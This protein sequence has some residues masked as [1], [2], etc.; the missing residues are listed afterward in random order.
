MTEAST[1]GQQRFIRGK[2][3]KGRTCA[4]LDVEGS[5]DLG[6]GGVIGLSES[7]SCW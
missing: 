5:E 7:P 1:A 3:R 2:R 6:L 4:F